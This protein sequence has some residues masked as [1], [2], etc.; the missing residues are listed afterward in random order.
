MIEHLTL[1]QL[2]VGNRILEGMN[3]LVP[4]Y[5]LIGD[6]RGKGLFIGMELVRDAKVGC[7]LMKTPL[8]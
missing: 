2:V 3:A 4:K 7:S 1:P 8:T 6:V 5:P